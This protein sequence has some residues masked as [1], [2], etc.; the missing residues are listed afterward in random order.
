[1]LTEGNFPEHQ[2]QSRIQASIGMYSAGVK[3]IPP[4][5]GGMLAPQE[6]TGPPVTHCKLS[7]EE[8]PVAVVLS[9]VTAGPKLFP[10]AKVLI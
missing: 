3:G 2:L 9:G 10:L 4:V 8:L 7:I 1:M 6:V 5:G